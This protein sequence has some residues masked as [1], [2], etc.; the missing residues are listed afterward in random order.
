MDW[1]EIFGNWVMLPR[2]P[3]GVIHFLGGAFVAAAPHITYRRLLEFL[4]DQGYVVVATPFVNTF[5]HESIAETVLWSFNRTM[6][7][8]HDRDG[9]DRHLPIYGLGHSMGCKLHLL[10]GSL[11]ESVDRAGNMLMS[12]NNFGAQEAIPFAAQMSAVPWLNQFTA[13]ATPSEF[14]P[15]PAE[16]NRLVANNYAIAHN[17]LIKFAND[18]LDQS[19]PLAQL[20]ET[21][22]PGKVTTQRLKGNHLTPLG[23]DVRLQ[24]GSPLTLPLEA[25]GQIVRQEFFKELAQVE[26]TIV[27]W[28]AV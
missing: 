19:I 8:L 14:T 5:D 23:Q 21:V 26:Q 2:R 11:F 28:L 1:Q 13:M 15:S 6:S 20:L 4:A 12:F 27:R 22:Y 16:T 9:I 3:I 17:L 7:I 24:T 25:F 10:I 18:S